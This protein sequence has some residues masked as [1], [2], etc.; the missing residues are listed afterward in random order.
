LENPPV[1]RL[2]LENLRVP[3]LRLENLPGLRLRLEKQPANLVPAKTSEIFLL[4]QVRGR[5]ASS[6]DFSSVH[7]GTRY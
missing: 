2:R 4:P 6:V 5:F 7:D 1:L 3:R